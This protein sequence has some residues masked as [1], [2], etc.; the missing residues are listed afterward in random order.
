MP[1][2][3]S[4]AAKKLKGTYQPGRDAARAKGKEKRYDRPKRRPPTP[5]LVL[6]PAPPKDVSKGERAIWQELAEPLNA[7]GGILPGQLGTFRLLCS[8]TAKL[9]S[10]RLPSGSF[11]PLV[12]AAN[13]LSQQLS[14]RPTALVDIP[15]PIEVE[16]AELPD[17]PS[18]YDDDGYPTFMG[19]PPFTA[20]NFDFDA[21]GGAKLRPEVIAAARREWQ[22]RCAA[23]R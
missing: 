13:K 12:G 2:R 20:A 17:H 21:P 14:A 18:D 22:K 23:Q 4:I 3:L 10:P 7:A 19:L 11:A 15:H 1:P 5:H 9:R 16:P 6:I 8:A